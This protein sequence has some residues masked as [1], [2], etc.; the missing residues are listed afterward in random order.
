LRLVFRTGALAG[1]GVEL[2][3]GVTLVGRADGCDLVVPDSGV[4]GDHV[5]L[6]VLAHDRVTVRDLESRNG[7]FADGERVDGVWTLAPGTELRFGPVVATLDAGTPGGAGGRRSRVGLAAAAVALVVLGAVAALA[8]AGALTGSGGDDGGTAA[9]PAG[10][11][12]ATPTPTPTATPTPTPAPFTPRDAIERGRRATVS[13]GVDGFPSGSGWVVDR[14]RRD[15]LVVTNDHVVAGGAEYTVALDGEAE[16]AA[17]L[18]SASGC[19]DLALMRVADPSG[20][21][22]LRLGF[23]PQLGDELWVMGFPDAA[24]DEPGLQVKAA[25][26]ARLGATLKDAD[27][28]TDAAYRDLVQVDG[29]VI[30]GNSGGP[31]I[32]QADGRVIGVNTLSED[33]RGRESVGYAIASARLTKVLEYLREGTSFPGMALELVEDASPP[34][35][36]GVTSPT[37]RRAGVPGD[38]TYELVAV[39]GKRFGADLEPGMRG[40]CGEL[41]ELGDGVSTPVTY[42]LRKP[43]GSALRVVLEY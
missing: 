30:P 23:R 14:D 21:R 10:T 17:T 36:I 27:R 1:H 13:V 8:L 20:L 19:D 43:D 38:G 31:L 18:V 5:E 4:S 33:I 29:A 9:A 32:A 3:P 16:R 6:T 39:D 22:A 28:P 34:R 35:I 37:L 25:S 2:P 7:T 42:R 41:P 26:V 24:T 40:L 11:P 12:A 15:A